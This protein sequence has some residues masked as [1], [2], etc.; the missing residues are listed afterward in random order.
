M[1]TI[2]YDTIPEE[3]WHQ[4]DP[5]TDGSLGVL[6]R[7]ESIPVAGGDTT[8]VYDVLRWTG[9]SYTDETGWPLE[10][11]YPDT[12]RYIVLQP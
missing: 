3:L 1:D 5:P 6:V 2:S 9:S 12:V 10:F 8:Y 7:W 4:G 11:T